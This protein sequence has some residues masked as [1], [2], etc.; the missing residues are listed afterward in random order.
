MLEE[1]N[2]KRKIKVCIVDDDPNIREIYGIELSQRGF[3][4]ITAK[5]GEEGLEV[6]KSQDPDIALVDIRMP[7]SDGIEL[8]RVLQKDKN[9]PKVPIVILTNQDDD[10]TVEKASELETYFYVVKALATPRKVADIV[11]EV[12]QNSPRK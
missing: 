4:V 8:I 9:S 6:I 5:D 10:E 2:I 3:E 12:L 1:T 11:E 7:K